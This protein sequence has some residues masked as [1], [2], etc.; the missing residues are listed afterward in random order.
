MHT[1]PGA[2]TKLLNAGQDFAIAIN[3]TLSDVAANKGKLLG[4][5]WIKTM[6]VTNTSSVLRN[7]I[8]EWQVP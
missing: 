1:D 5:E 8:L 7:T 2:I 3:Y 4:S 6:R